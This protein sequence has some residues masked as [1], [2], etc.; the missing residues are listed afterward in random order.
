[1]A[2]SALLRGAGRCRMSAQSRFHGDSFVPQLAGSVDVFDV[3]LLPP[4]ASSE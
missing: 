4:C 1:M 3:A 2:L